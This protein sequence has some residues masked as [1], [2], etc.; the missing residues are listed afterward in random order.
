MQASRQ[1]SFIIL[2]LGLIHSIQYLSAARIRQQQ[3]SH[4]IRLVPSK[5]GRVGQSTKSYDEQRPTIRAQPF[6]AIE[7]PLV[8]ED[9]KDFETLCHLK[10]YLIATGSD[11]Q[12]GAT[13]ERT[14]IL[15]PLIIIW[16][17]HR[18][19]H[20]TI[21]V[22]NDL[23]NIMSDSRSLV[24]FNV[25]K[26]VI[27]Q[28]DERGRCSST[29]RSSFGESHLNDRNGK[30]SQKKMGNCLDSTSSHLRPILRTF[31]EDH[32]V[33]IPKFSLCD[34][35]VGSREL[36]RW[37]DLLTRRGTRSN[38]KPPAGERKAQTNVVVSPVT[39]TLRANVDNPLWQITSSTTDP[40][41]VVTTE[42]Y[43]HLNQPYSTTIVFKLNDDKTPTPSEPERS[44]AEAVR[45]DTSSLN[46][47]LS[48]RNMSSSVI[49]D[50]ET[51]IVRSNA[52]APM[53]VGSMAQNLNITSYPEFLSIVSSIL[54][55]IDQISNS[56]NS[57][58]I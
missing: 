14:I 44:I 10:D 41:T 56:T 19:P 22:F 5:N 1:L 3:H 25:V 4:Q 6:G 12:V 45:P 46:V 34:R 8:L 37:F 57:S 2:L 53:T 38:L 20:A 30:F 49:N 40:T 17:N 48:S 39:Q 16:W 11:Q 9:L 42:P 28:M 29:T 52:T 27:K 35:Q 51:D 18:H 50:G 13:N 23:N 55:D 33:E 26:E 47:T 36:K 15:I 32:G 21:T 24:S 31:F 54:A 43:S 7:S 58:Q